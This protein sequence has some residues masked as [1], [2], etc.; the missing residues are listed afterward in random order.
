MVDG[1]DDLAGI[2]SLETNRRDPEMGMPEL[3][4]DDRQRDPFVG[5]FDG[6]SMPQ[7]VWREPPSHTGLSGESAQLTAGSCR[8]PAPTA[9]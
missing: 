9:G 7:L 3:P 1:V 2:D 4:L 5:H 8:R 6:V